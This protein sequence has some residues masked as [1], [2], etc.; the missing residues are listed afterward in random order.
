MID[1]LALLRQTA[2]L[3]IIYIL[4]NRIL[5]KSLCW[6]TVTHVL[7]VPCKYTQDVQRHGIEYNRQVR[8]NNTLP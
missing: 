4:V 7:D 8:E 2:L 3:R 5:L 1:V 6:S